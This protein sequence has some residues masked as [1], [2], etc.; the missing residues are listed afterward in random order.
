MENKN[1]QI[2]YNQLKD[3]LSLIIENKMNESYSIL[4]QSNK[5]I[6]ENRRI[7]E[8]FLE[9]RYQIDKIENIEKLT[10]K[11]NDTLISHEIRI[12]NNKSEISSI[13]TKYDKI[14]LDNLLVSGFIGPSCQFKNLSS[15]IKN[16]ITEL[17]KIRFENE[18]IKKDTKEFKIRLD[19]ASKNITSLIDSG[20]LRCNQYT[21]SRINDFHVILENKLKEINDKFMDIRM[22]NIQFQSK[23]EEQISNLKNEFDEKMVKQKE[24]IIQIINNK[25]EYINMNYLSLEKNPKLLEID[26]IK[27]NIIQLQNSLKD[28]KQNIQN[29]KIDNGYYY[30]NNQI[31]NKL[32]KNKKKF[33]LREADNLYESVKNNTVNNSVINNKRNMYSNSDNKND[34][35]NG[36]QKVKNDYT[37]DI[38]NH[39]DRNLLSPTKSK[40][41]KN[42]LNSNSQK[43]TPS[44]Y[45]VL[46]NKKENNKNEDFFIKNEESRNV[47]IPKK[48][49]TKTNLINLSE[50]IDIIE[51]MDENPLEKINNNNSHI[52]NQNNN[53]EINKENSNKIIYIE[54]SKHKIDFRKMNTNLTTSKDEK[55]HSFISISNS[56]KQENAIETE[57]NIDLKSKIQIKN[58]S[59][60]NNKNN[61]LEKKLE[62][63]S[64]DKI[65][66]GSKHLK[67]KIKNSKINYTDNESKINTKI[68]FNKS[69]GIYKDEIVKELFSKYNKE[70]ISANLSLIKNKANIDLYNYSMSPP[71]NRFLLNAKVNEIIEPP[72]KEFIFDRN[73]NYDKN[74]RQCN[75]K[76]NITLRPSL[77][78][79]LFYGN[80]N[81]KRKERITKKIKNVSNSEQKF[82]INLKNNNNYRKLKPSFGK[83]IYSDF[84]KKEELFTM[85]SYKISNNK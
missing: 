16:N 73:I 59:N 76:R 7:I 22:K 33:L 3:E 48:F 21:D 39:K 19:G 14:V 80:F 34:I 12:A 23:L 64:I 20:V 40:F 11:C 63:N 50:K 60:N 66:K 37:V 49:H 78:M 83:T 58:K 84:I 17:G 46:S 51:N 53:Q 45:K 71:D 26:E 72:V 67:D 30:N 62:L 56:S 44:S 85:T 29:S 10:N 32:K 38:K 9:Q 35:F 41:Y 5:T 55:S 82:H 47:S 65:D 79:Q 75:T 24:E 2:I 36:M 43:K 70:S 18:N 77:N 25:M 15:Y 61:I 27:K 8:C 4:S 31:E 1:I 81:E 13:K 68:G 54:N 6:E 52:F 74:Q 69:I 57:N 42:N 28:I